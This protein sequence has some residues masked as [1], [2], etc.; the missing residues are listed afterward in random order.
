[1]FVKALQFFSSL[2]LQVAAAQRRLKEAL[3]RQKE[4]NDKRANQQQL[5]NRQMENLGPR[6]RVGTRTYTSLTY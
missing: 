4:A 1:M 5:H 6:M 2:L 3:R